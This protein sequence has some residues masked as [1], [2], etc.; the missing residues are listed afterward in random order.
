[1]LFRSVEVGNEEGNVVAFDGLSPQDNEVLG[2]HHHEP[3]ELMTED[4]F[5]LVGLFNGN[6]DSDR[7]H[8]C[9]DEN[10]LLLVTRDHY[11]IQDKLL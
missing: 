7:I 5:D 8:R 6:T 10:A 9:L 1:M 2:T 4:F 3:G 11:W